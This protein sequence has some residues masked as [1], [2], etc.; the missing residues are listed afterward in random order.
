[1]QGHNPRHYRISHSWHQLRV[2]TLNADFSADHRVGSFTWEKKTFS[3]ERGFVSEMKAWVARG[4]SS[5]LQHRG[6]E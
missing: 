6:A 3:S 2:K 1:M 4:D 5:C